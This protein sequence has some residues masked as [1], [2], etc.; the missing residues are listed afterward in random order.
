MIIAL[1]LNRLIGRASGSLPWRLPGDLARFK[2]MT[3]GSS[4]IVG[5][6]T[7]STLPPLP[8]RKILVAFAGNLAELCR[9]NPA[10]W[11]A[12]GAQIYSAALQAKLV[13]EV[14]ATRVMRSTSTSPVDVFVGAHWENDM[15]LRSVVLGDDAGTVYE[16]WAR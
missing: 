6:R 8:G 4:L 5:R 9:D 1:D 16:H 7:A 2:R 3:M 13:T 14:Y 10:A 12:G 11:I 15:E